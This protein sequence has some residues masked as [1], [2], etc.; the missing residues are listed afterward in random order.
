MCFSLLWWALMSDGFICV[1][2]R[3]LV[4]NTAVVEKPAVGRYEYFNNRRTNARGDIQSFY[5]RIAERNNHYIFF[6]FFQKKKA[7]LFICDTCFLG[8]TIDA[9]LRGF[10]TLYSLILEAKL[11]VLFCLFG[12]KTILYERAASRSTFSFWH[13][14][15][16]S[17][18]HQL[19]EPIYKKAK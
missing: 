16:D 2:A 9:S 11:N 5:S 12:W 6:C 17:F 4:H 8:V 14:L 3:S 1:C 10:D 19:I 18:A 13:W 7:A 15:T